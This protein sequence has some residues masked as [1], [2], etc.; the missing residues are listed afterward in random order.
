[1]NSYRKSA[2]AL[3]FLARLLRLCPL[4]ML[5]G[6]YV[7]PVS[8][9]ILWSYKYKLYAS[10]QKRMTVCHYLGFHGVVR[11]QDGEQCP[12]MIMLD[13]GHWF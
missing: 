11:Y 12:T 9:H 10:G 5:A 3:R 6:L 4:L 8:P 7:A 2:I 1:M 13:R